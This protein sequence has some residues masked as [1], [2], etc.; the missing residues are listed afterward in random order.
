MNSCCWL[1]HFQRF[2][3]KYR[4][5]FPPRSG[6]VE[7]GGKKIDKLNATHVGT[8]KG[9]FQWDGRNREFLDAECRPL[10]QPLLHTWQP[11]SETVTSKWLQLRILPHIPTACP[12]AL[13]CRQ[14]H[15]LTAMLSIC[16]SSY[17]LSGASFLEDRNRSPVTLYP[18]DRHKF[19]WFS[20]LRR[21]ALNCWVV[22]LCLMPF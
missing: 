18:A 13:C 2:S 7:K 9:S 14:L 6:L 1:M 17:V 10:H 11:F 3:Y 22:L 5:F 4:C 20:L 15:I 8:R 16:L 21:E 19:F 12:E